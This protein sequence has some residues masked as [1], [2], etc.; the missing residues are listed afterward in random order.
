MPPI[1]FQKP[2]IQTHGLNI[3]VRPLLAF[4]KLT[5]A[6]SANFRNDC[7]FQ[8]EPAQ[9]LVSGDVIEACLAYRA[10]EEADRTDRF[11]AGRERE[12][13]EASGR[14][15]NHENARNRR[16]GPASGNHKPR[17][18]PEK[19]QTCCNAHDSQV[20]LHKQ[21]TSV[22]TNFPLNKAG[23]W[24]EVDGMSSGLISLMAIGRRFEAPER[25]PGHPVVNAI[26]G[27]MNPTISEGA[28]GAPIVQCESGEV[29]GFFHLSDGTNCL[30][31]DLDDLIAKG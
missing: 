27:A 22:G 25:P 4:A 20:Y 19:R 29:A 10:R 9:R 3:L 13:E 30:T 1:P 26:F 31:A 12:E 23:S 8:A 11:T 16:K 2:R 17:K 5:P 6:A 21:R 24:S 7:Y 18:S 28:C 15:G 14:G